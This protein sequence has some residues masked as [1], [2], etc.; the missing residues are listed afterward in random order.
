MD[1]FRPIPTIDLFWRETRI[2]KPILTDEIE[3]AIRES[4][5]DKG[6]NG[7]D[8]GAE[9]PFTIFELLFRLLR[10]VWST[11]T[12]NRLIISRAG[13]IPAVTNSGRLFC[14][15]FAQLNSIF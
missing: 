13:R 3:G 9:V 12:A 14:Q 5:K 8:S 4:A 15:A 2:I 11:P 6:W 7:V 1:Y 10:S